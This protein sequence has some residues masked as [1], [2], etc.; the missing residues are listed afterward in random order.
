M[1]ADLII[2]TYNRP[3]ALEAVLVSVIHQTVMPNRVIIA[4][5]GSTGFTKDLIQRYQEIFPTRL[6]YEWQENEG[7]RAAQSRNRALAQ[8]EAEYVIIIDGDM[9]L[10]KHFVEDHI[11]YARKGCFLQGGRILL[12]ERKT[13]EVL[14]EPGHLFAPSI[15]DKGLES[16]IEKQLTAFRSTWLAR[17]WG[18]ELKDR[19][20]IRSCNMSFYMTDIKRVN[21]FNN[22][23]IGWG[24]EDSEFVARLIN[25]GIKGVI[26]KF[27]ALGYHLYHQEENR[28]AL[29]RN[30]ELL[31]RAIE[32]KLTYCADGLSKFL[33]GDKDSL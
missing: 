15:F 7:F 6:L 8:V 22:A 30:D 23:F 11:T 20:K 9:V 17:L 25:S 2:T 26:I 29:D 4:D 18:K 13:Q 12:T 19:N 1:K 24:R 32:N 3:D 10:E 31:R 28:A 21:G 33:T 5:D 16:R 27:V 14:Q